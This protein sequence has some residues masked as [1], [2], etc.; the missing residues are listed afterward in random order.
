MGVIPISEFEFSFARSSGPG[1]QNVNKV[2]SKCILRWNAMKSS[3][4]N[5]EARGRFFQMF[6]NR[7]TVDGMLVVSSEKFRDQKRNRAH[8]IE[9][10]QTM[11]SSILRPAKKR[12]KT[13]PTASSKKKRLENKKAHSGKKTLRQKNWD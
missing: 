3:S 5:D 9:K 4:L 8:C 11:V 12:N 6:S 2:N 1:G 7:L 13:K 10:V